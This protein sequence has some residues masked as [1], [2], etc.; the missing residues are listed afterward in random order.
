MTALPLCIKK[1]HYSSLSHNSEKLNYGNVHFVQMKVAPLN[2]SWKS[3][4]IEA[5]ND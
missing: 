2:R 3:I 4:S 1:L 5:K